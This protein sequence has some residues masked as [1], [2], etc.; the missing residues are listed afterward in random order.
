MLE[1]NNKK[2]LLGIKKKCYYAYLKKN[3]DRYFWNIKKYALS[4]I[5]KD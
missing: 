3:A 5:K 4:A 2:V 1:D